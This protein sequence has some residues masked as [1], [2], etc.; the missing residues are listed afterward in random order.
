MFNLIAVRVSSQNC[1][2]YS[3]SHAQ[4]TVPVAPKTF[5]IDPAITIQD[6]LNKKCVECGEWEALLTWDRFANR[7]IPE[8][9]LAL[10]VFDILT[11]EDGR[12]TWGNGQ[13]F[14]KGGRRFG[15]LILMSS[16]VQDNSICAFRWRGHLRQGA[17][18]D[19]RVHQG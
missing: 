17:L 19:T 7:L 14:Y 13:M 6:A 12:V 3:S 4:D 10:S 16:L 5:G 1:V 18:D 2:N 8:R 11:A 9:G 15:E